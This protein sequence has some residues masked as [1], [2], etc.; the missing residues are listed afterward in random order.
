MEMVPPSAASAAPDDLALVVAVLSHGLPPRALEEARAHVDRLLERG[1]AGELDRELLEL[2]V[3]THLRPLPENREWR[4][5]H[6]RVRRRLVRDAQHDLPEDGRDR[7]QVAAEARIAAAR[8]AR[9]HL[10]GVGLAT[11]EVGDLVTRTLEVDLAADVGD[12]A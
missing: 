8:A 1:D 7:V 3:A 4:T 2:T 9:L 12:G 6:G 10:H 5:R 11:R